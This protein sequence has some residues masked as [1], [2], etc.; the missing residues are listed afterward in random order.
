M[1]MKLFNR[2]LLN[3]FPELLASPYARR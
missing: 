2:Y 3:F 1:L